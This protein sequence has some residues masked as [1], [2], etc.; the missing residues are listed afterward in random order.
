[1][2]N[3]ARCIHM[4]LFGTNTYLSFEK[5]F[6][7]GPQAAQLHWVDSIKCFLDGDIQMLIIIV[8]CC[9]TLWGV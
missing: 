7:I 4:C 2:Q 5:C 9:S 1:M 6:V 8:A 3:V